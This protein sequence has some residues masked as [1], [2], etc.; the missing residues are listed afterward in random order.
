MVNEF[1]DRSYSCGE[2]CRCMYAT[3]LEPVCRVSG[4]GVLNQ[5]GYKTGRT[6]EWIGIL[7]AIVM[8]YRLLGLL[9]LWMRK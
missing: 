9:A 1:Q 7:L 8:G 4:T 3:D 6:G 2:G 5:Y